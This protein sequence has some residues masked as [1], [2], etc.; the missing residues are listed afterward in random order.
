M[1]RTSQHNY[2]KRSQNLDVVAVYQDQD[3]RGT[4]RVAH[5]QTLNTRSQ[6]RPTTATVNTHPWGRMGTGATSTYCH[7]ARYS[8]L[9][10]WARPRQNTHLH[11]TGIKASTGGLDSD[12]IFTAARYL[13]I[14]VR[15]LC[16]SITVLDTGHAIFTRPYGTAQRHGAPSMFVGALL[17]SVLASHTGCGDGTCTAC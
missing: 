15:A 2:S 11:H 8:T 4:H 5:I 12:H 7:T 14:P 1:R 13:L 6:R 3:V 17:I 10:T 16:L 9:L